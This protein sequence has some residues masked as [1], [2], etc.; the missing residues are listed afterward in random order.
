MK[1]SLRQLKK[2]LKSFAKRCRDFKYTEAAVFVFLLVGML[3]ITG[4]IFA[5]IDVSNKEIIE[6]TKEIGNSINHIK[7]EF[8]QARKENN[9]LLKNL[10][11]L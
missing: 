11:R 6:K 3:G 8:K 4:N 7:L 9:K 1:D 2:D 10:K 5:N